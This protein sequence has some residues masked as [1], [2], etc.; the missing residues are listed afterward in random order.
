MERIARMTTRHRKEIRPDFMGERAAV[1]R[2]TGRPNTVASLQADFVALGIEPG[3]VLLVH[4]SLSSLGWVS[5]GPVA[6]I[7]ALEGVLGPSG[8]L[9][10]PTHSSDLSDPAN[11][12][13]PPVPDI[14]WDVIRDTMPPYDP[15]L[16]PTRGMGSIPETFRKQQGVLRSGHP[17]DSFAA[18]G[19]QAATVTQGH[20]LDFGLGEGS[21]L[22]R[23]YDLDGWV[24][25]LGVSH[26]NNTSLHLAE[27]RASYPSK[28]IVHAGAP[29]QVDGQRVWVTMRDVDLD[30]DDFAR[31]GAHFEQETRLARRARVGEAEATL[32]PQRALV[33][34]AV[35]WIET[36]R[37]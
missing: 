34:Y 17:Q 26:A 3:R 9:V 27:Y 37:L 2:K 19:A 21:P 23:V 24:L 14:W 4:S 30:S 5:G 29:M 25:L 20:T 6:V 18:W 35:R 31:I 7:L 22:A 36:H 28:R 15:D 16:T 32:M 11:W 8:T 1:E 33:D 13:N 12:Q 10:M